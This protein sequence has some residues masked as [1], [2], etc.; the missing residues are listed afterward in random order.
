MQGCTYPSDLTEEQ[1]AL[2]QPLLPPPKSDK[3]KGGRPVEVDL[4]RMLN[5]IMY[6]IRTGSQWRMLPK[7]FGPWSTVHHYYRQYRR[8]GTLKRIHDTLREQVRVQAGRAPTPSA[9][10]IDSQ[11]V[12]TAEK[13][14]IAA[15]MR[16]RRSKAENATSSSI[17]W[18]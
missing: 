4:H 15:T 7:E 17:R 5:G 11:S 3:V 14:G 13:G 10:I 1:F 9:A 16:A 18:G 6:L 8:D 2:I 12:K